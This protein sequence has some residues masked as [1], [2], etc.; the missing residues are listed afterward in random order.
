MSTKTKDKK[1]KVETPTMTLEEMREALAGEEKMVHLILSKASYDIPSFLKGKTPAELAQFL[2]ETA[3]RENF[4]D[5][6]V[7]DNRSI[8]V[9]KKRRKYVRSGYSYGGKYVDRVTTENEGPYWV[10]IA[11]EPY[12]DE[13]LLENG[14]KLVEKKRKRDAAAAKKLQK[15][16]DDFNLRARELG[17]PTISVEDLQ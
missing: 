10:L 2:Y 14:M 4:P 12:T 7:L 15:K 3:E 9:T 5:D 16:V 6:F 17:Q 8:P 13:E 11:Y 1:T